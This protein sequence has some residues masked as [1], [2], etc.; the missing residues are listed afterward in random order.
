MGEEKPQEPGL[1]LS[2]LVQPTWAARPVETRQPSEPRPP[3]SPPRDMPGTSKRFRSGAV[4]A[5]ERVAANAIDLIVT[6]PLIASFI[7]ISLPLTNF[8]VPQGPPESDAAGYARFGLFLILIWFS[9]PFTPMVYTCAAY[10]IFG[11]TFGK[12]VRGL[13]VLGPDSVR[14]SRTRLLLRSAPKWGLFLSLVVAWCGLSQIIFAVFEPAPGTATDKVFTGLFPLPWLVL[15]FVSALDM[16]LPAAR[17]DRRSLTDMLTGT[18]II[19]R[20]G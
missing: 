5:S 18:V 2:M 11:N 3:F 10:G 14:T 6:A 12:W 1:R 7:A 20:K 17:S 19:W 8:L 15:L 4:P 9:L 16:L 13:G